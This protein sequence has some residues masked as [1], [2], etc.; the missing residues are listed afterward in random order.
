MTHPKKPYLYFYVLCMYMYRITFYILLPFERILLPVPVPTGFTVQLFY[1]HSNG[2]MFHTTRSN[3]IQCITFAFPSERAYILYYSFQRDA[4][5]N[6]FPF[7]RACI[8]YYPFQ[9]DAIYNIFIPV[10]TGLYFI[11]P[12]PTVLNV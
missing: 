4:V 5:Y 6:L 12:V 2:P 1:S 3:G 11:L 8:L 10:R 7:E 9:R